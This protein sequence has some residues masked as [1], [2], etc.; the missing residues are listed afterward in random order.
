[1]IEADYV[2]S[3]LDSVFA[4]L[5]SKEMISHDVMIDKV[6]INLCND[7]VGSDDFIGG[8]ETVCS[9]ARRCKKNEDIYY[10]ES[11][12]SDGYY[13]FRAKSEEALWRKIQAGLKKEQ[14]RRVRR[15]R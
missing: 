13:L 10:L 14:N 12:D 2:K 6:L 9:I 8:L 11:I 5:S 4:K 7:S 1:M 15:V 3:K